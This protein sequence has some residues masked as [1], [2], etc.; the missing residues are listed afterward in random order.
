MI[1]LV[2]MAMAHSTS[3]ILCTLPNVDAYSM[4]FSLDGSTLAVE[5]G[6]GE[7]SPW[8]NRNKSALTQ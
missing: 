7:V 1:T 6:D 2:D 4:A 3:P 8:D 5:S